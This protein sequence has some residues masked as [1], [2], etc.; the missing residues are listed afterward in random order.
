MW[1]TGG[2]E[3]LR[4]LLIAEDDALRERWRQPRSGWEWLSEEDRELQVND[5]SIDFA[6]WPAG[7]GVVVDAAVRVDARR[8]PHRELAY[9]GRDWHKCFVLDEHD[10]LT[11]YV[12]VAQ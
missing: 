3:G 6:F 1:R 10:R 5:W 8:L 9:G 4:S 11:E 12:E 2:T 7:G